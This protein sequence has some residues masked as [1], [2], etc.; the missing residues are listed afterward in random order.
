MQILN[1][2]ETI[3]EGDNADIWSHDSGGGCGNCAAGRD[4]GALK[5]K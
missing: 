1:N 4:L 2:R 3:D 5:N